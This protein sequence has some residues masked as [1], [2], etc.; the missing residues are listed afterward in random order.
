MLLNPVQYVEATHWFVIGEAMQTGSMYSDIWDGLA[1]LSA[2]L[3][4]AFTWLFGRSILMLMIFGSLLTFFQAAI[5][6]TFSINAKIFENNTYLPALIYVLLT[7]THPAFFTLSPSLMG[8]TFVLLGLGMLIS[9]VEFRAKTDIHIILIGLYF[10]ISTLFHL[11]FVIIIP[12]SVVLLLLFSN[13]IIRRYL[14][15]LFT[16]FTPLIVAFLYYWVISDHPAYFSYHFLLISNYDTNY[17]SIG[18]VKG[19]IV[20]GF[21]IFFFVL[22][23]LTIGKQ[24]RLTNYQNRIVQ[25]FFVLAVLMMSFLLFYKPITPY[26]LVVFIPVASYF[27]VHFVALFK[28]PIYTFLLNIMLLVGPVAILWG[29]N[30]N[31]FPQ[32]NSTLVTSSLDEYKQVVNGKRVMILGSAKH[33]YKEAALAGPFYDWGLSKP[34]FKNLDYYDNLVFL[35]NQLAQTRPEVIID[36]E[37]NW[38]TISQ[39]LPEV[40]AKYRMKQPNVWVLKD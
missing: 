15:L 32:V 34:F 37:H 26:S 11:A 28:R 33:L 4:Q 18:W 23:F 39:N 31:W 14:L 24:R 19:A 8:L 12:I 30:Q 3:Y 29:I 9:H 5:I 35:Q 10:G 2:T 17:T 16:S 1:P 40:A 6:N 22:G 20:L 36:L 21:S 7:S 13:T 25:L 38:Y 27:T